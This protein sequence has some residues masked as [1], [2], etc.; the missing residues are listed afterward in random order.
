MAQ[1]KPTP[2]IMG[3]VLA[4]PTDR[5]LIRAQLRYD[6]SALAATD[7]AIVQSAAVDIVEYRKRGHWPHA[8]TG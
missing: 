6:Y 8:I 2:D 1:R 3:D 4:A 5:Q 7:R